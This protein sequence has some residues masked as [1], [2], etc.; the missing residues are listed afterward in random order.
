ME[1]DALFR[2]YGSD[3]DRN[4]YSPTYHALFK[5]IRD[6]EIDFMEIG[7]GTMIPGVYSSMVG[8]ALPGYAPGGSLRAWRDFFHNG[9][10]VGV[11]VQPDTQF[12]E[13]RIETFLCNT[14]DS[15]AACRLF[16]ELEGRE[17][18]VILDD[19][20]HHDAHQ[21]D[22]LKNFYPHVKAGGYYIIED[23]YP[24]SRILAEFYPIIQ[25]IVG[26]SL[27]FSAFIIEEPRPKIPIVIISKRG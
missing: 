3:K 6:K 22:T 18:D 14:M 20:A 16:E 1:L 2:K 27:I 4:G 26:D 17:F 23:V 21:L 8:Y 5:N 24:G 25:K 11:D 12:T 9:R 13:D 7:I 19:G 10:I 15:A